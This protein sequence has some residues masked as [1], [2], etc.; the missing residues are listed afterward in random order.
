MRKMIVSLLFVLLT[1]SVASAQQ[2]TEGLVLDQNIQASYNP[3]GVQ[4]VTKL[5]YRIPLVR[6]P[7]I[8]WESTKIE[9][10]IQNNLSPAF[11]YAGAYVNIEPIALFNLTLTAQAV[12]YYT[13]LGYGLYPL[14][15]YGAGYDSSALDSVTAKNGTGLLLSAAPTIKAAVGPIAVLDTGSLTWFRANGGTGYFYEIA[16]DTVLA[17][18]D[19]EIGNQAY[20]LATV[21]PGL[22]FG[23][24]DGVLYVPASG[25][26]S[27][28]L[29][30]IGVYS[31]SL[32]KKFAV[33]GALVAGTFL[34]D[35]NYQYKLY[36]AGQ[37]GVT[38][39]L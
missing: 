30:A 36:L 9:L 37:A 7:G 17:G 19:I 8:L 27:H 1:I 5:F 28:R 29:S 35:R 18:S 21:F 14:S 23:I 32:S 10:G 39:G 31:A 22:R 11:D 33:Y 3:L 24:N 16:G 6:R 25:Y 26:V 13:A 4:L 34:T 2:A 15:G 38:L 12:A 20:V